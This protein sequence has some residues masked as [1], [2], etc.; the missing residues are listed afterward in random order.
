MLIII[1]IL[2]IVIIMILTT[3]LVESN[4]SVI[5]DTDS[6]STS[7]IGTHSLDC[8]LVGTLCQVKDTFTETIVLESLLRSGSKDLIIFHSINLGGHTKRFTIVEDLKHITTVLEV[9]D[10]DTSAGIDVQVK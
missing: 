9:S 8:D 4:V 3:L 2:I 7:F 1:I 5:Q 6:S 10:L